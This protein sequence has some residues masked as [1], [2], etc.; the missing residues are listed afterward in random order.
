MRQ[1]MNVAEAY[2]VIA[3]HHSAELV[4]TAVGTSTQ[5]WHRIH[6]PWGDD[7]FH[8]HT[9]GLTSSFSLGLALA[10][11]DRQVWA[12]DGDG[13]LLLSLGALV[14]LAQHRPPN[15]KY[16]ITSNRQH[17]TIE[18]PPIV[19]A[20]QLDYVRL[21]TALGIDLAAAF[22]DVGELERALPELI[23]TPSFG[24]IALEVDSHRESKPHAPYEGAEIKYRFGR[25]IEQVTGTPV[26]GSAGY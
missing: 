12:F 15:L 20:E 17:R 18:G 9:M 26:F 7:A 23:A 19:G 16:F 14:T 24:V 21:A 22:A 6:G 13:G 5:E 25:Y 2:R 11:P 3:K 4:V 1:N 8:M 10:Q